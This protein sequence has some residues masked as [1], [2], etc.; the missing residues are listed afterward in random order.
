MDLRAAQQSPKEF[1]STFPKSLAHM[2][3]RSVLSRGCKGGIL[4]PPHHGSFSLIYTMFSQLCTWPIYVLFVLL[5]LHATCKIKPWIF[6]CSW[7]PTGWL[8]QRLYPADLHK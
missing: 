7:L 6:Y 2:F 8:L 1:F 3:D 4:P 5:P